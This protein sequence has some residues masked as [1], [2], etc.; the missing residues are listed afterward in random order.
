M[1]NCQLGHGLLMYFLYKSVSFIEEVSYSIYV[2]LFENV[3]NV[4][5]TTLTLFQENTLDFSFNQPQTVCQHKA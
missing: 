2:W 3:V 5:I 4:N 1:T